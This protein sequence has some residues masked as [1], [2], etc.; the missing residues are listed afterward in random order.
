MSKSEK[1]IRLLTIKE[2][3]NEAEAIASMMRN[4]GYAIRSANVEDGEDLTES[5]NQQSW[6]LIVSSM[7]LPEFTAA[8][9]LEI[10]KQ[11]G[12]DI[13][14]VVTAAAYDAD[15][16]VELMSAGAR[17]LVP[18]ANHE[19][20]LLVI[21]R[22][23]SD[24]EERRGHRHCKTMYRESERRNRSL[25]DS[26]RDAI[27]YI[28]DGMHI[29]TNATYLEMFGYAEAA[30]VEGVPIMDL[31]A[32]ENQQQFK[33]ILKLLNAGETP[34]DD[35]EMSL[36][37][38]DSDKFPGVMVFAPASIDG[39]PCT[40]VLIR[41]KAD[42]K[43]LEQ[44]L[45]A[46]RRQDL[47]TGL[48]NRNHFMEQLELAI[49]SATNEKASKASALLMLEPD[50]FKQ[51]TETV[52]VAAGDLVLSDLAGI[53]KANIGPNDIA[54]RYAGE[55]FTII[56]NDS[57]IAR[58][59]K[60]GE[61]LLKAVADHVFDLESQ[62]IT[63]TCSIGIVQITEKSSDSKKALGHADL[64]CKQ[65]KSDGGNQIHVHT[66]AD[67]KANNERDLEWI[68][69]IQQA[70]EKERF[71]LVYQPIVSLH[72]EPGERYEI[73]LRMLDEQNK[74]IM[75][76]EF[77]PIAERAGLMPEIDRWVTKQAVKVLATK[78]NTSKNTQ[79]FIKLSNESLKDQTLLVWVSKLL[80][81]ARLH[82]ACLVF[83]ASESSVLGALK[84]T[85]MF[86]NGL[87]QLHCEF[88]IDHVGSETQSFSYLKHLDVKFLKIH[89]A[90][91]ANL[92]A[93]DK[94]RDTL[95][96]ITDIARGENKHT[97]AEHVQDANC[98]AVLWQ[99]GVNFIQGYYLQKPEEGMNYD[100]TSS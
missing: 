12:K 34:A 13:P 47:L 67:E 21:A 41:G 62:P 100:F 45:D 17:E 4:A 91:I 96:M 59:K 93:D 24:L 43:A 6:D 80:Q 89:G 77:L 22:E 52:G 37:R 88:A 87:K 68:R 73:L 72:A 86:I 64:A 79:L 55:V 60:L 57:D 46:L 71:R 92:M 5:L 49:K 48:F 78:R 8:D 29:Y 19:L 95:K 11:S 84:E 61:K 56:V 28:A 40:Q 35:V 75:P 74:D 23:L 14:V 97:I 65:V 15:V 36:I 76:G 53:I 32:A 38:S 51:I 58:V 1:V 3:S 7:K 94:C 27:A 18:D 70:I 50:D 2:S 42:N 20:L 10:V 9:A 98:L 33:G 16:A 44:E 90:I 63:T 85:K 39:E 81:A 69:K 30:D 26:S 82:G 99:S 31:I 25:M 66:A 54:A 83:E